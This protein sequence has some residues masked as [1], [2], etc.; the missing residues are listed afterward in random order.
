MQL[1]KS[2]NTF[3][4]GLFLAVTGCIAAMLLAFFSRITAAPIAESALQE[5]GKSLKAVLPECVNQP[6]KTGIE[7][8]DIKFYGAFDSKSQIT[9]VA[10][11]HSVKGYGGN[12][13]VLVGL[14]IDGTVRNVL[15]LENNETPGLGSNV[16]VRKEQKTL[17]NLFSSAKT[18]ADTLP[19]NRIL[20]YY[21][22][23][24]VTESDNEWKVEKDGGS[25]PYLTGAT[26]SSRAVCAAVYK[27]T[28]VY[29]KNREAVNEELTA[30]YGREGK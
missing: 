5:A 3:V 24:T 26:I 27:I 9:G 7:F 18:A 23:K 17:K 25:C 20:D 16:C 8:E 10:G 13:R 29:C 30:A 4:L 28:S 11:E 15:V 1:S 14:N 2:E 6:V 19:P 22:G 12:I 21:K